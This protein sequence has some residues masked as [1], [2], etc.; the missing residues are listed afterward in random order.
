MLWAIFALFGAT[1]NRAGGSNGG[2]DG[3]G[4]GG[5]NGEL[6]GETLA[7]FHAGDRAVMGALFRSHAAQAVATL[8]RRLPRIDA[9]AVVQEAF[10]TLLG[11][12]AQ[13]RRFT[14]GRF[15]AYLCTMA[16]FRGIDAWRKEQRFVDEAAAPEPTDDQSDAEERVAARELLSKFHDRAVPPPQKGYFQLRFIEQKT[17]VEAAQQLGMQRSTCATWEKRLTERLRRSVVSGEVGY[18][19]QEG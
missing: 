12:E 7:R 10:V 13:R 11:S 19:A 17:Q 15:A 4:N 1:T 5:G 18:V 2:G 3:G 8:H 16:R 9:E 6:D 14:G